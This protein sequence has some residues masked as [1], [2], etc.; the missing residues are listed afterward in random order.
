MRLIGVHLAQRLQ[1][2]A[3]HVA[4][5]RGEKC[6]PIALY[7]GAI[8]AFGEAKIEIAIAPAGRMPHA[9]AVHNGG[10]SQHC[11]LQNRSARFRLHS[12]IVPDELVP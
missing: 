8:C 5:Y 7:L 12:Y 11:R 1:L 9:E 6:R 10:D 2:P 3:P 4:G